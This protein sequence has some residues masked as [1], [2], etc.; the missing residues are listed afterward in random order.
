[1][2]E[3]CSLVALRLQVTRESEYCMAFMGVLGGPN[4]PIIEWNC[5]YYY[6]D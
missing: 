2:K 4:N 6:Y 1:M 3:R 5:N